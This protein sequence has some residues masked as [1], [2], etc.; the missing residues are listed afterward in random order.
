M[1]H[2]RVLRR[3]LVEAWLREVKLEL[4]L[5]LRGRPLQSSCAP[6]GCW[7]CCLQAVHAGSSCSN[8]SLM[9]QSFC[10]AAAPARSQ[11]EDVRSCAHFLMLALVLDFLNRAVPGTGDPG[12]TRPL[13][14][15]PAPDTC[16][17]SC[18]AARQN[19]SCSEASHEVDAPQVLRPEHE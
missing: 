4:Q 18:S 14:N 8:F 6:R 2:E 11:D 9:T 16:S 19:V 7:S 1:S 10:S 3:C 12:L 13:Q 17:S 5:R 15:H